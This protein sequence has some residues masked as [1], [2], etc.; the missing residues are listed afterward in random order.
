M[1][2]VVAVVVV[3]VVA[4]VVVVPV[5]VLSHTYMYHGSGKC[6]LHVV[7]LS[8][9]FLNLRVLI[10]VG[11]VDLGSTSRGCA[12]GGA[13]HAGAHLMCQM[14]MDGR[15]EGWMGQQH[16]HAARTHALWAADG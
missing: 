5:L 11:V 13:T 10:V 9:N 3:V 4:V 12:A 16:A 15:M 2:V 7:A 6:W 1:V 8:V 14:E